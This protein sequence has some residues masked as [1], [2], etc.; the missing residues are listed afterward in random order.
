LADIRINQL[1]TAASP[2]ATLNVA[3][4]GA[5]TEKVTIQTLVDTGRPLASQAEAEAGTNPSKA[6][7]P[8]T[9][10][11]AIT[12][13]VSTAGISGDYNDLGNLPTLGTAAAQDA[14]AFA[15][16]AQGATAD[17]AVQP[18]DL[19]D[20]AALDVGTTAGTVAAG[21]DTRIVNAVQTSRTLT[22]GTGLTGGGDL[23]ANRT[24]ALNAASIASL[25]LAD[26]AA[27]KAQNLSDLANK[28][29]A[30]SNLAMA[31]RPVDV[32]YYGAVSGGSA[33][34]LLTAF[35]A[36]IDALPVGGGVIGVPSGDFSALVAS[37]LTVG[38][39]AVTFDCRTRV[40]PD[41]TFGNGTSFPGQVLRNGVFS[42]AEST[43]QTNRNARVHE[44]S[45]FGN[46]QV[47][48]S[49]RQYAYHVEAH[50]P[51]G[52]VGS[53]AEFR[54]YSAHLTTDT[55]NINHDIRAYKGS[56]TALGGGGNL[57]AM[58]AFTEAA[59]ASGFTGLLTGLLATIYS[60]GN[61]V[62]EAVGVRSHVSDGCT[63]GFQAGGSGISGETGAVSFGY[64]LRTGTGQPLKP[65]TAGFQSHGGGAGAMFIGYRSNTDLTPIFTV[66]NVGE[67]VAPGYRSG[68]VSVADDAVTS[69]TPPSLT[70]GVFEMD[71]TSADQLWARAKIRASGTH[72]CRAAGTNGTSIALSTSVLTG[73][74]G[75]DGQVTI[76]CNN[77]VVQIENRSG[78][79]RQFVYTFTCIS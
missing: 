21:D 70:E 38:D 9:T 32:T 20:A 59:P 25:A 43:I 28:L 49:T 29:T 8:L 24:V 56:V 3:V 35:Q 62:T 22:A 30:K 5:A 72:L 53:E 2:V 41:T 33:G 63:A 51:D 71:T 48:G 40:E 39:K 61:A 19:G 34:A 4:D 77:G 26:S 68:A 17:S 74:T 7:T 55:T 18:G 66:T 16:A 64:S 15:T 58:Y 46:T 75:V 31:T 57:R 47:T 65:L 79:S 78:A 6:M 13:Q 44:Y 54:G 69:I 52:I 10:K 67:V 27:Q 1:P 37:S 42:L 11:Q 36:A 60:N 23:S 73:T 76:S 50:L 45:D 14:T 12:A